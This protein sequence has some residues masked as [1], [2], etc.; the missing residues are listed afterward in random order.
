MKYTM[1]RDAQRLWRWR[2]QASN[3]KTIAVSSESYHNESDCLHSINLVK[4]S[5]NAP[6]YKTT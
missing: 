2:F 3:G 5:R 6:V 1:Y 4:A